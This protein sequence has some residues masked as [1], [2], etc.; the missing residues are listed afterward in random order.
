MRS[1]QLQL[2][3]YETD[4]IGYLERYDPI[5]APW[6]NKEIKLLEVGVNKGGSLQLW[7]DYFPLG[8]VVGIDHKLPEEFAPG[9]RIQVF[10]GSQ[11]DEEFLSEVAG[12]TAPQGFD[13]IIDDASHLG[14]L[15]KKTF[16]HLFDN[17]LKPGGLYVIEDWGTGYWEDWP[18]GKT[19][20]SVKPT[21]S[22]LHS[23]FK[24][25]SDDDMKVPFPCHSYGMVGFIKELID[26]QC[27]ADISRK[28]ETSV[29]SRRSKFES[30]LITPSIVFVTKVDAQY[31]PG[32]GR[33]DEQ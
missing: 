21:V 5:L 26:E 31:L 25:S 22:R 1:K 3:S 18:D 4:K 28:L 8:H 30:V 33:H 9:E 13:I 16:W 7:R 6:V 32:G 12:K 17:H 15:T 23:F 2:D 11:A 19:F 10:E 24:R 14:E 27:A 20:E 29:P